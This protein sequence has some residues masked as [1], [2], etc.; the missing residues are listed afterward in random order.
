MR[1]TRR[2]KIRRVWMQ[3]D[4]PGVAIFDVDPPLERGEVEIDLSDLVAPER[5]PELTPAEAAA[6]EDLTRDR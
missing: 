5:A 1:K 3:G 4:E 6:Y 2:Q